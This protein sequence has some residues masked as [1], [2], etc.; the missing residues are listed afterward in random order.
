MK[1]SQQTTSEIRDYVRETQTWETLTRL[2]N[3]VTSRSSVSQLLTG[4][5]ITSIPMA[6]TA[7][8]KA[9]KIENM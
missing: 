8:Q 9:T 4:S 1:G 7:G 3:S 5:Y 2:R 6:T